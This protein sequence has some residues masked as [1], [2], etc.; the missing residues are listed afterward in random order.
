ML[1]SI[2]QGRTENWQMGQTLGEHV[3]LSLIKSIAEEGSQVFLDNFFFVNKASFA[4][5]STRSDRVWH[6]QD[7]QKGPASGSQS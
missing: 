3:V 2:Y 1:F 4:V 6:F 7:K 5:S